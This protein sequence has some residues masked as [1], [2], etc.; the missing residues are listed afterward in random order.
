MQGTNPLTMRCTYITPCGWCARQNKECDIEETKK[1]NKKYGDLFK[2]PT[3]ANNICKTEEDHQWECCGVSTGGST[4]RC[5]ICG[6]HKSVPITSSE[7]STI[8]AHLTN[9]TSKSCDECD[10]KGWDMPECKECNTANNFK[11]FERKKTN[12]NN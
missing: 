12:G 5:K 10:H 6:E 1:R 7:L 8:S 2:S 3:I 11:Y 4:Y 9:Q